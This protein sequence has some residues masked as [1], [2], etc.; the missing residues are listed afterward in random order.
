MAAK[1]TSISR[2]IHWPLLIRAVIFAA[3]WWYLPAWLFVAVVCGIYFFPPFE[4]QRNFPAF[5]VL[6]GIAIATPPSVL[7]AVIYGVL[8]YYLLLIKDF[9]VVDRKSARTIFAMALSFLLFRE[10]FLTWHS[11][12]SSGS[13]LWAWIIAAAFGILM[14]GVIA[15]RRGKEINDERGS[16][17]RHAAVGVSAFFLLEILAA[18][19]FLPMDFIDQSIVVFL[20]AAFLLDLVPAYF[21]RELE[22][23]RI[24]TTAITL[25]TLLVIVLASVKWGI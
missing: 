6:L 12:I 19:L 21:F 13:L 1:L 23:R 2:Q 3:A 15:A 25:A 17:A 11:G 8:F 7:M 4:V 5:F 10:F 22:P 16:R 24:R 20:A 9:L 14:N 18:C